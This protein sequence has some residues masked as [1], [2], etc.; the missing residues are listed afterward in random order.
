MHSV[1][2]N[3]TELLQIVRDNLVKHLAAYEESV[4]DYKTAVLKIATD[5]LKL[6]KTADPKKFKDM[7]MSP[8]SPTSYENSYNRAIRMLELSVDDVVELEDDVFN[9]L[10]LDEWQWKASFTASSASY[11][12]LA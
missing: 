7:R 6:A 8:T 12:S 3:K 1:K 2:L 5:N 9:Q 11:K 4:A 10:V